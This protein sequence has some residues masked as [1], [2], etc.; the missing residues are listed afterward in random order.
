MAMTTDRAGVWGRRTVRLGLTRNSPSVTDE[1]TPAA[2]SDVAARVGEVTAVKGR[3]RW[4]A[5]YANRLLVSDI[6]AL[7]LAAIVVHTVPV[8]AIGP[9]ETLAETS[10][11]YLATTV[12]LS[13]VWLVALALFGSRD[14]R[15]SGYG[16][17]EYK[18][19]INATFAVFGIAA[20]MSYLFKLELSRGYLLVM[21][22]VGLT[23]LLIGRYSW[24]RWLHRVRD[25]GEYLSK[26]LAVGNLATVTELVRE[27]KR[28][29]RAGYEVVGVCLHQSRRAL[30]ADGGPVLDVDGVPVVG[31]F[32][33]IVDVV[34]LT[35]ADTV[36]VTS[37]AAFGPTSVRKLSWALEDTDAEL[38]LAPAL[39]NIAG[40]R[41]HTQPVDGLPLIHVDRPT[42]HGANR[43]LKKMFDVV[44]SSLLIL[45]FSPILIGVAIAIKLTSRGPV[46]FRQERVGINGEMFR[47]IKFRSMVTDAE[48]RLATLRD[49]Q[50]DAGNTVL[51]KMKNDPRVTSVGRFIRRYSIDEL[52]QLFNVFKGD[53]SLVGPRP[54]LKAEVDLYEDEARLRLLVKPGMTGLWQVSGRSNLSWDDSVRLDVFYV[55]NWSITG[56]LVIMF[57]TVKAVMTGSGAF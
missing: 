52:P 39:T 57:K 5:R 16:A 7:V 29:P 21:L 18:R 44:G 28:T 47:M 14:P 25:S 40:P 46:F 56:D 26:V 19:I 9:G 15:F 4:G 51:F 23:L 8:P 37:S 48:S 12:L 33:D 30:D 50:Q 53:M 24:R 42:Y 55:E 17:A 54:P 43:L 3:R 22:P 6:G 32:E 49:E 10:I 13:A 34:R 38:I 45:A 20:I 1:S 27:L 35:G 11:P 36:A 2:P 41:I 31:S